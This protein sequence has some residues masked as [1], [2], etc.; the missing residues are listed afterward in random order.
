MRAYAIL[1]FLTAC[2]LPALAA[3]DPCKAVPDHGAAPAW[4]AHG[5][6]VTGPVVY[7]G[8][9]DSLCVA[10]GDGPANWVEIRLADFYAPELRAPGGAEAKATLQRLT[11]GRILTCVVDHQTYDRV[12]AV[13]RLR[14]KS[15]GDRMREAGIPEGGRG[16]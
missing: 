10:A 3:A 15:L 13:C 9:G 1:V 16:R 4:L 8:D 7:I 12:A 2:G 14:G 6:T 5:A 11:R